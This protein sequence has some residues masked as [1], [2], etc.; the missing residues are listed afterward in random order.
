ML[1]PNHQQHLTLG[2]IASWWTPDPFVIVTLF[3][4]TVVYAR[5]VI[6]LARRGHT[7]RNREVLCYAAGILAI[8]VALLSPIDRLSDI[9]FSAHMGQHEILILVAPPL[10]VLGR[11]FAVAPFAF[12]D[13]F[14]AAITE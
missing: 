8:A 10:L 3:A 1:C 7:V 12:G 4:A 9:L 6:G 5:G 2:E 14:R 13:P 11:P